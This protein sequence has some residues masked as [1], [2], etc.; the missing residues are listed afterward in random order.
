MPMQKNSDKRIIAGLDIGSSEVSAIACEIDDKGD[1]DV[2]GVGVRSS[3]GIQ[4]GMISDIEAAVLSIQQAVDEAAVLSRQN[5]DTVYVGITGNHIRSHNSQGAA[6]IRGHE[7]TQDDINRFMESASAVNVASHEEVLHVLPQSF[8]LDG[9][10]GIK[11]PIGLSGSRLEVGVHVVTASSSAVQNI[12]KCIGMCN[13]E[14]GALIL[15]NVASSQAVLTD[16]EKELGIAV[17]DIGDGT[18]DLAIYDQ[19]SIQHSASF[20]VGG[21][22]ITSDIAIVLRTSTEL[23]KKI[24]HRYG[25]ALHDELGKDRLAEVPTIGEHQIHGI[26]QFDLV[27]VIVSRLDQIF[28]QISEHINK[29][30]LLGMMR[31][32][33]VLTGGAARL[34]GIQTVMERYF[35]I[36]VRLGH[37]RYGGSMSEIIRHPKLATAMGL[38]EYVA[39]NEQ[40]YYSMKNQR[41]DDHGA[42]RLSRFLDNLLRN[43]RNLQI[44]SAPSSAPDAARTWLNSNSQ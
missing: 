11:N 29:N 6:T 38:C 26:C 33:I 25:T 32:G 1:I 4:K 19:G 3:E 24:K 17:L 41:R 30:E 5:I 9:Q 21:S 2:A 31:S 15:T 35:D 36:P 44:N 7:V 12:F 37:A 18:T 27:E 42:N 39:T 40:Y 23:A 20:P 28:S 34:D 16:D 43:Y 22:Q 13:L 8:S 14:V 10:S